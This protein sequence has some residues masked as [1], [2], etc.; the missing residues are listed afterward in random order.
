MTETLHVNSTMDTKGKPLVLWSLGKAKG[1]LTL[2][3][4]RNHADLIIRACAIAESEAAIVKGMSALSP[5]KKGFGGGDDK[6]DDLPW[7]LLHLIRDFRPPLGDG[8]N[9]IYGLKTKMALV[10]ID[11]YGDKIQ[12]DVESARHHAYALLSASEASESDAFFY[13][14]LKTKLDLD[15]HELQPMMR[16]FEVFRNVNRLEDLYR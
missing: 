5:K 10:E 8:I 7:Q 15:P 1:T 4:A 14:F 16:E 13:H 9:V 11:G 12:W 3:E 2:T 6:T